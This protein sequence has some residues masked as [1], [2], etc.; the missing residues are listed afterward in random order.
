[1]AKK[2]HSALIEETRLLELPGDFLINFRAARRTDRWAATHSAQEGEAASMRTRRSKARAA[3]TTKPPASLEGAAPTMRSLREELPE[4]L[5]V[6]F[7]YL[8]PASGL[9]LMECSRRWRDKSRSDIAFWEVLW[10]AWFLSTFGHLDGTEGYEAQPHVWRNRYEHK[11]R[12]RLEAGKRAMGLEIGRSITDYDLRSVFLDEQIDRIPVDFS[13]EIDGEYHTF[14][15]EGV[16]AVED[17][18]GNA[19]ELFYCWLYDHHT[20]EYDGHACPNDLDVNLQAVHALYSR[21]DSRYVHPASTDIALGGITVYSEVR[22]GSNLSSRYLY[23]PERP[24]VGRRRVGPGSTLRELLDAYGFSVERVHQIRS[25]I[26]LRRAGRFHEPAFELRGVDGLVFCLD[27][28]DGFAQLADF[29]PEE[30]LAQRLWAIQV[31]KVDP[32]REDDSGDSGSE[33]D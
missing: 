18:G 23:D 25:G 31:I 9:A 13:Y 22:S 15:R 17:V 24:A 21:G 20:D 30:L 8:R 33:G 2:Q 16:L 7:E 26:H 4:L 27:C 14:P 1:M 11:W 12:F 19:S 5:G 29:A 6:V 10:K 32:E 3:T 28:D